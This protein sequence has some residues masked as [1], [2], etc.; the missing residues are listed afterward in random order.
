MVWLYHLQGKEQEAFQALV[1][2]LRSLGVAP[3]VLERAQQ[4]FESGGMTAILRL[5][6]ALQEHEATLGQKNQD[7]RLILYSLL[8]EK[9]RCFELLE[10][11]FQEGN[12]S[13][14]WLPVSPLFDNLRADPRYGEFIARLGFQAPV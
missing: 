5:W 8:N 14:L 13:L 10:R 1:T 9:D 7:D 2:S 3:P 6:A 4:A 12:P 11:A